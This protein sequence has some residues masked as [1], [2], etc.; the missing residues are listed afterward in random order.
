MKYPHLSYF[1][2]IFL[3]TGGLSGGVVKPD[4]YSP[5]NRE[6]G[7]ETII[8]YEQGFVDDNFTIQCAVNATLWNKLKPLSQSFDTYSDED[9]DTTS[10]KNV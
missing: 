7:H 2:R 9:D 8:A 10:I 1:N 4:S 5:A 6:Y 3:N